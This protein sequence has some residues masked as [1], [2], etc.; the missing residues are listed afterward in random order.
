M[1]RDDCGATAHV[2]RCDWE[3]HG[4]YHRYTGLEGHSPLVPRDV[5]NSRWTLVELC[6][7][8]KQQLVVRVSWTTARRGQFIVPWPLLNRDDSSDADREHA[9]LHR[10]LD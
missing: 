8:T 3:D 4:S 10:S 2:G 7:S 5:P 1:E 6:Q 9:V